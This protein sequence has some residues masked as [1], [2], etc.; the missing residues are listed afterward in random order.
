MPLVDGFGNPVRSGDGSI[1]R[2]GSDAPNDGAAGPRPNFSFSEIKSK[3]GAFLDKGA[4]FLDPSNLR[5]KI[6]GLFSG[7]Q[8]SPISRANTPIQLGFNYGGNEVTVTDDWRVRVSLPADAYYFWRDEGQGNQIMSPLSGTDGVIFPYT[9]NITVTHAARYGEQKLTHSNYASF[10]YEGS[11]VSAITISGEFTVQTP[12]EGRYLL[13]AVQF[14]RSATKM[15]F[16]RDINPAAGTPPPLVT[17]D[18]YG[19][20]Y[21]P[22]VPCVITSFSHTMPADVD[23]VEVPTGL[24]GEEPG[25]ANF[26]TGTRLP[27]VSTISVTLQPVYSRN[28][29]ADFSLVEFSSGRLLGANGGPGR[30]I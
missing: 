30:F 15:F 23:Y 4:Q 11:E 20:N 24:D 2:T 25:R 12:D 21:F 22:S 8:N 19:A 7:G 28:Q 6:S 29:V 27:T 17:L 3:T 14:F 9:P 10:F 18:G 1:V 5:K 16:G 13:A 26:T